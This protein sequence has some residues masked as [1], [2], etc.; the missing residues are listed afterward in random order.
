MVGFY[1]AKLNAGDSEVVAFHLLR[2][3]EMSRREVLRWEIRL[4]WE[5]LCHGPMD[6]S[7]EFGF[8]FSHAFRREGPNGN[9][10]GT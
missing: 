4:E 6:G 3:C 9:A 7:C 5:S 2:R 8:R 1:Q 10:A